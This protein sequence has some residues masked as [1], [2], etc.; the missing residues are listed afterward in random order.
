MDESTLPVF[1]ST[2]SRPFVYEKDERPF[3]MS[4][5]RLPDRA[6]D[7][8]DEAAQWGRLA[9][10]AARRAAAAKRTIKRRREGRR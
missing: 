7:D 3:Q 1:R 10:E 2:D 9:I 6:A 8:P 4:Y 5:W